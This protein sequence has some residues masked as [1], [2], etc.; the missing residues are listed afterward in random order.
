[1]LRWKSAYKIYPNLSEI[2][3]DFD[4]FIRENP[5][6]LHQPGFLTSNGKVTQEQMKERMELLQKEL[7]ATRRLMNK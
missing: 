1:M 4:E 3:R 6:G 7:R 2:I 5:T